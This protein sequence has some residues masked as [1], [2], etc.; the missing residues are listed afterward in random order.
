MSNDV[1]F[2]NDILEKEEIKGEEYHDGTGLSLESREIAVAQSNLSNAS[3]SESEPSSDFDAKFGISEVIPRMRHLQDIDLQVAKSKLDGKRCVSVE[4]ACQT[5]DGSNSLHEGKVLCSDLPGTLQTE[6][7]NKIESCITRV[8][9]CINSTQSVTKGS[10]KISQKRK[11]QSSSSCPEESSYKKRD[12]RRTL[13][14]VLKN[15]NKEVAVL[16]C[17]RSGI[18]SSNGDCHIRVS[19][20]DGVE[21]T[22]SKDVPDQGASELWP[23]SELEGLDHQLSI[24]QS[25]FLSKRGSDRATMHT[26]RVPTSCW[27]YC[28]DDDG[29]PPLTS[30]HMDFSSLLGSSKMDPKNEGGRFLSHYP[31]VVH[32]GSAT[33]ANTPKYQNTGPFKCIQG[34]SSVSDDVGNETYNVIHTGGG[35]VKQSQEPLRE[36]TTWQLKRRRNNRRCSHHVAAYHKQDIGCSQQDKPEDKGCKPPRNVTQNSWKRPLREKK[37][38][39][40]GSSEQTRCSMKRVSECEMVEW[41]NISSSTS[42]LQFN[43][44]CSR[45]KQGFKWLN[46]TLGLGIG[47]GKES[48][49]LVSL[50][51][52]FMNK[53]VLGYPVAV[54]VLE[55]KAIAWPEDKLG[56]TVKQQKAARQVLR[57]AKFKSLNQGSNRATVSKLGSKHKVYKS[58]RRLCSTFQKTRSLSSLGSVDYPVKKEEPDVHTE[59]PK[60]PLVT[61]IPVHLVFQRIRE[62]IYKEPCTLSKNDKKVTA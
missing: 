57:C 32:T 54:Q 26:D 19:C 33:S 11:K 56:T 50:F 21:A 38:D 28:W 25:N 29:W 18:L 46:V 8:T 43:S 20:S 4:K 31:G 48:G 15:S 52:D 24:Y 40:L 3:S 17:K 7:E 2:S 45:E 27:S 42:A 34:N 55:S 51:S 59:A 30:A 47:H 16:G 9:A 53:M 39:L 49:D 62:A 5:M 41:K 44:I 60:A 10:S 61:C 22:S 12:R 37:L 6:G 1:C 35:K 14:Q 23:T 36:L 13:T 58:S